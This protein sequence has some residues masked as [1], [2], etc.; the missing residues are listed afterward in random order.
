MTKEDLIKTATDILG[1]VFQKES[2]FE[3]IIDAVSSED[4]KLLSEWKQQLEF[5]L[6]NVKNPEVVSAI[7][8][9]SPIYHHDRV[10]KER[11]Q[12]IINILINYKES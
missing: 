4:E 2:G 6:L 1:R 11:I 8:A 10:N 7:N 12:S 9:Q 3:T 5:Y